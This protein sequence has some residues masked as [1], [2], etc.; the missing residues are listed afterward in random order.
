MDKKIVREKLS[1]LRGTIISDATVIERALG[2]KLRVYFSQKPINK[3]LI[4]FIIL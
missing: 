1:L 2:W 3:P 4:F